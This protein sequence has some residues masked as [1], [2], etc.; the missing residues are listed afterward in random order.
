MQ[1]FY[2]TRLYRFVVHPFY[3]VPPCPR[4]NKQLHKCDQNP[5]QCSKREAA[6][7]LFHLAQLLLLLGFRHTGIVSGIGKGNLESGEK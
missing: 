7:K 1:L 2:T 3:S 4:A 5:P 6:A